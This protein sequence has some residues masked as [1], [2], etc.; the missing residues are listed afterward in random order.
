MK[1]TKPTKAISPPPEPFQKKCLIY[2]R[3]ST[4]DQETENQLAQLRDYARKQDWQVVDE[5]IDIASGGKSS[6]EREGL[7]H[8]FQLAHR[9]SYDILLFWALDRFSREGSRKTI[10]YLTILDD[11]G[12]AWHSFTEQYLSSLGI[13]K[14]CIISLLSTLARQEKIRISERTKAGLERT[15]RVNGTRLGRPK[16]PPERLQKALRLRKEGLSYAQI[17]ERLGVSRI[18]AFQMVKGATGVKRRIS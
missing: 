13:F 4:R 10:A 18:R 2:A 16:T 1:T 15:R 7:D 11:Y 8:V 6:K 14:D 3:C 5:I 12:V 17:A 9:K